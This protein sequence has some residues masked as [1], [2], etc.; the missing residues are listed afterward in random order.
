MAE[1]KKSSRA[2]WIVGA[3]VVFGVLGAIGNGQKGTASS[4]STAESNAPEA[5]ETPVQSG[6]ITGKVGT[7][8]LING[9]EVTVLS[10]ETWGGDGVV[11]MPAPGNVYIGFEVKLAA[12]D[13][14]HLVTSGAF[15]VATIAGK[16]GSS[17]FAFR[18]S[19]KPVLVLEDIKKG[20][21]VQGWFTFEVEKGSDVYLTYDD[22]SFDDNVNI[23]WTFTSK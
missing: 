6:E 21:Y 1:V 23:R 4:G 16:Q 22:S 13:A 3:I 5:S 11:Q 10:A 8:V 19:W 20:Q 12:V 7:P 17:A 18:N 14:D 9:V 15:D 2:K